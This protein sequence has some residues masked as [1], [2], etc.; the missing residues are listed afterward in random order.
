M[1]KKGYLKGNNWKKLMKKNIPWK[2]TQKESLLIL[3]NK[4]YNLNQSQ[5]WI[6]LL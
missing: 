4:I 2:V 5:N 6:M 1:I 3:R